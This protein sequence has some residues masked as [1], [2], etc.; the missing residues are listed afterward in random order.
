M[1]A[2]AVLG[3]VLLVAVWAKAVDPA[4]FAEQIRTEKLDFALSAPAIALLAL[5]LEAGLGLALLLGVRRNWVLVPATLLVAFFLFL[6][7]RAWWLSAH[8]L[9]DAAASCG[10]FGN[11]VQRT[12]AEAF[13]QD[14]LLLVPPL[15]LAFVGRGS[16]GIEDLSSRRCA[17]R[18]WLSARSRWR[19]SPGRRRSCRSTT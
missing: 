16:R 12:P 18:W 15:V 17:P 11:L 14:L 6:T 9:R 10:C 8:G 19:S 3:I 7:G 2:G 5:A 1:I 4:S 13:W